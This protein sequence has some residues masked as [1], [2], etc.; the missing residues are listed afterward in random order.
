MSSI[1]NNSTIAE[2]SLA[3]NIFRA[4]PD[5]FEPHWHFHSKIEISLIKSGFGTRYVGDNIQS[6]TAPEL[7]IV[8]AGIPHQWV[9][10]NNSPD[11]SAIVI[12]FHRDLFER[13]P[14][15][16][17]LLPFLDR[18]NSG[19]LFQPSP[20]IIQLFENAA[21]N[22]SS[23]QL[24]FLIGMISYLKEAE[25]RDLS[26]SI[27]YLNRRN[28]QID[29]SD[30]IIKHILSNL[31]R[32]ISL[33][34][35]A[36]ASDLS[37]PSFCRWFKAATGNTFVNFINLSRIERAGQ[38]LLNT[39]ISITE[40]GYFVGFESVSQFN[41]TFKAIKKMSPREYRSSER[42]TVTSEL[43]V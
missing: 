8:G 31:E 25:A 19:L 22:E 26:V 10:A 34:E 42:D 9:S 38:L 16:H 23:L 1:N 7:V 43:N 17:S 12:H 18:S 39:K 33:D 37:K 30:K 27:N 35:M 40:L 24:S 41:R 14:A 29:K 2:N 36:I 32:P 13:I 6:F 4:E 21:D 11:C 15:C 5:S 20:H 28:L 3:I